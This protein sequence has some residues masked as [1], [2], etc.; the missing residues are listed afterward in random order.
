MRSDVRKVQRRSM[1]RD[2][3]A[4][5]T[6]IL[7]DDQ[8][9]CRV[10]LRTK[11]LKIKK[12]PLPFGKG[13]DVENDSKLAVR[14]RRGQRSLSEINAEARAPDRDILVFVQV[15]ICRDV[16]VLIPLIAFHRA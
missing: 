12:A 9:Y 3:N 2:R 8:S 14:H 7:E 1:S 15:G 11:R 5:L 6:T 4:T 16:V 10:R 13:G